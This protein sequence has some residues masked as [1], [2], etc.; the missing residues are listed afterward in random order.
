MQA[1]ASL[2]DRVSD[3]L[4]RICGWAYFAV[5]LILGYEVVARYF[6]NAPTIWAE[7]LSRLIFVFATLL[8]APALLRHNQHIR[9]TALTALMGQ[10][11]QRVARLVALGVV[12]VFC[13][14]L[15]WHG[16][17][18][19]LNSLARGRTSG[20]M[21][22]IPAWWAQS[23]VPLAFALVGLQAL[24]EF[25]RCVMGAALPSDAPHPE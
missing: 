6:F 4:A 1:I 12:I 19:P 14:L 9:V 22:D 18:A 16:V 17:D 7:E 5:G 3:G 15:V 10:R 13:A 20:S 11:A 24:L 25:L 23:A 2:V 21:L 8:A